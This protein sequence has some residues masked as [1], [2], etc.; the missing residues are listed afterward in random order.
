MINL[1]LYII[2]LIAGIG[3]GYLAARPYENRVMHLEDLILALKILQAEMEY[4]SDPLPIL[5]ER[6]S[7]CTTGKAVVFF[8]TV[9]DSLK[10]DDRYDFSYTWKQAVEDVYSESALVEADRVIL[11]NAGIEL[12]KT[13]MASQQAM[14]SHLFHKLEKQREQA[15]EERNTKGRIYRAL[16][17]ASGVLAVI[18]LL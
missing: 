3:V 7:S 1:M 17:T 9:C 11:A 15:E 6:I 12:G 2:I 10:K 4:R 18:I 8:R 13:D 5:M 14:F 16:G